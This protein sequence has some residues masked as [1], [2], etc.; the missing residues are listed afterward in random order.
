MKKTQIHGKPEQ[1]HGK[2]IG[3][4]E[5]KSV[6]GGGGTSA[7]EALGMA[8]KELKSSKTLEEADKRMR[9]LMAQIKNEGG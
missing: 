4:E 5:M 6:A 9:E 3:D 8:Y 2:E 7:L 1:W